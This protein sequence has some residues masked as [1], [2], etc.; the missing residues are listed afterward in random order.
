MDIIDSISGSYQSP[1]VYPLS[2]KK[3]LE[4]QQQSYSSF[5]MDVI[6]DCLRRNRGRPKTDVVEE[7]RSKMERFS[8]QSG[9]GHSKWIFAIGYDVASDVLD[10]LISE[11]V[12]N[13]R[14]YM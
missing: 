9:N 7:F 8:C 1:K 14:D 2:T 10:H 6:I 11:E 3:Q 13:G 12:Q 5:F 4:F